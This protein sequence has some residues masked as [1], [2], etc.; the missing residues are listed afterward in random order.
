[1]P[2]PSSLFHVLENKMEK[3]KIKWPYPLEGVGFGCWD[4]DKMNKIF[5]KA[6]VGSVENEGEDEAKNKVHVDFG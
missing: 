4:G 3:V 5:K 2:T 1:M 6:V